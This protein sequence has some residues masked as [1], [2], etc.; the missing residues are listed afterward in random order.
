[1][2]VG[3]IDFHSMAK[4]QTFLKISTWLSKLQNLHLADMFIQTYI[5]LKASM[6]QFMHSLVTEPMTRGIDGVMLYLL[7]YKN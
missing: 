7:S 3:N 1:M 6:I 2:N 5:V 4:K